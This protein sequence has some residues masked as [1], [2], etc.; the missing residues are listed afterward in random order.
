M[1]GINASSSFPKLTPSRV[2]PSYNAAFAQPLPPDQSLPKREKFIGFARDEASARML[3]TVLAPQLRDSNQIHVVDFRASLAIL[4]AMT[5]PEIVLIDLSGEDQPINAV[6][7]LA[8]VVEP[9]TVVMAI[10]ETINV[11]FYRT[12]TKGMGIKEYLPK[13]LNHATLEQNF[14]PII[15]NMAKDNTVRRSGRFVVFAG[16]RGGVGTST[17]ATNLAWLIGNELHRHTALVDAELH[18]GTIALNLNLNVNN[19]LGT[20]LAVPERVDQLLLERSMQPAG[21]RLHVLAG[22][23][24]LDKDF[25]YKPGS[26]GT[27][28]SALH[29]RYNFVVMDA[30]NRLSPF[31]RDLLNL[32]QQRIIVMDPSMVSVRNLERLHTLPGERSQ[33][34]RPLVVLNRA[35]TPGGLSQ[36]YMEQS[37]G[38]RFDAVIP[39]LPRSVPKASQ[40]GT[41]AASVRGPFRDAIATLAKALGAT[42]SAEIP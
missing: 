33:S 38:L 36:S 31:S 23:E 42:S 5:T 11:N 13:P 40:F 2:A 24:G 39:D 12:V 25:T 41:P 28:I 6:M 27:L 22:Q 10:G 34:S 32:A 20:A 17:V 1:S 4:S 7:E 21:D 15:S 29:A 26:G 35:Q 18:T 16:T 8:E 9:G 30:G 3:H 19:G 37:L 14:L